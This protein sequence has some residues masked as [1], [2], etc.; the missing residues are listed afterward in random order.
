MLNNTISHNYLRI[1]YD[2]YIPRGVLEKLLLFIY[3]E[4]IAYTQDIFL[5]IGHWV[6]E[7]ED[8][9]FNSLVNQSS[10][11]FYSMSVSHI[12]TKTNV[13]RREPIFEYPL[14]NNIIILLQVSKNRQKQN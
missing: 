11:H 9:L 3:L 10:D 8:F 4:K 1:F 6:L 5:T 12:V 7:F 13:F 14:N 2:T